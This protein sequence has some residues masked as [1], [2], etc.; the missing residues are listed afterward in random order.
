[1]KN[2]DG[3]GILKEYSKKGKKILIHHGFSDK[4]IKS[5]SIGSSRLVIEE[6]RCLEKN[7]LPCE[8]IKE[9]PAS[10]IMGS[11]F[12]KVNKYLLENRR[13]RRYLGKLRKL[14]ATLFLASTLFGYFM[15]KNDS[16]KM[17]FGDDK[18]IIVNSPFNIF[19][20]DPK[21]T[22][23]IIEHNVEWKFHEERV[24]RN[25]ITKKLISSLKKIELE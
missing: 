3:L 24:W 10:G 2:D 5:N 16:E 25:F 4:E 12:H 19:I 6:I 7:G 8:T 18:L 11:S 22:M 1:M 21:Q 20:F 9:E 15:K 13:L 17:Y 14:K 23:I